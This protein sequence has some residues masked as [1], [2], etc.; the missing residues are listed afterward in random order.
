MKVLVTGVGGQLGYD[1][2]SELRRRNIEHIGV[3]IE[4]FDITDAQVTEK[5]IKNYNPVAVI[6]CSAYTAVDRAEDEVELCYLVN[7]EGTRNIAQACS[8]IGAKMMYISTDYVYQGIGV[9]PYIVGDQTGPLSVY[10]RSKLQGEEYLQELTDNYFI[11]RTAWVFGAHGHNF[12]KTMLRLGQERD[13]INVVADQIGSP[14]YTADLASLLCDM[15]VT[16][17]YG[18]YHATNEGYCSWAEF[19]EEIFSVA[20]YKTIVKYITTDDYPTRAIRPKNSKMSKAKLSDNGF[21]RL[22]TWQDA[23]GRYINAVNI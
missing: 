7:A 8:D 6:H 5:F 12:V 11:V 19:A 17:K 14:T 22:P 23:L 15:I 20:G 10:G 1:V 18:V 16:D 9:E 2:C 3:D 4:D 21:N 13:E